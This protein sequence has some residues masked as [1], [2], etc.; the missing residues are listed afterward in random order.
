[1][2]PILLLP[3]L[4]QFFPSCLIQLLNQLHGVDW[5]IFAECHQK[6]RQSKKSSKSVKCFSGNYLGTINLNQNWLLIF[7]YLRTWCVSLSGFW[8]VDQKLEQPFN[9]QNLIYK[10]LL[11]LKISIPSNLKTF[12]FRS[13]SM[14]TIITFS[15]LI[16][17]CECLCA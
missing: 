17:V 9:I 2:S 13:E 8:M 5:W 10:R 12:T 4:L 3:E 1:M 15:M 14:I 11:S 7:Y 6:L 16:Y